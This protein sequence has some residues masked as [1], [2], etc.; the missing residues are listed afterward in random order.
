MDGAWRQL[1]LIS[2]RLCALTLWILGTDEHVTYAGTEAAPVAHCGAQRTRMC[3]VTTFEDSCNHDR[4]IIHVPFKHSLTFN[5]PSWC[6]GADTC[7]HADMVIHGPHSRPECGVG[8]LGVLGNQW[9]ISPN[10]GWTSCAIRAV[11]LDSSTSCASNRRV[12]STQMP[13]A[14]SASPTLAWHAWHTRSG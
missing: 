5:Q 10:V 4:V 1:K 12:P 8:E 9:P 2:A 6:L 13:L 14:S 11:P 3:F 7:W